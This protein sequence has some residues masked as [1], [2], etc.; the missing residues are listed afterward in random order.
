[1]CAQ[2]VTSKLT[3][4]IDANGKMAEPYE[5]FF[6]RLAKICSKFLRDKCSIFS[7]ALLNMLILLNCR[8]ITVLACAG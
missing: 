5:K 2:E 3:T 7:R 8:H 4:A 6:P 1:M